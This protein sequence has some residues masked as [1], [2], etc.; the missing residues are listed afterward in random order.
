MVEKFLQDIYIYIY[1]LNDQIPKQ[2][3]PFHIRPLQHYP[4]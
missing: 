4:A 1:E 2:L 3:D